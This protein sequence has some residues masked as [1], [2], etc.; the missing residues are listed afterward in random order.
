MAPKLP[1]DNSVVADNISEKESVVKTPLPLA[2]VSP[3][4]E[5]PITVVPPAVISNPA[6]PAA[7]P[8]PPVKANPVTSN[9]NP[10]I[11]HQNHIKFLKYQ[12]N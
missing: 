9:W 7:P 5:K 12:K 3:A 2:I 10:A 4:I 1:N 6:S 11:D 8:D